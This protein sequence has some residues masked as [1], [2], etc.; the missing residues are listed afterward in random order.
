MP[1]TFFLSIVTFEILW[2]NHEVIKFNVDQFGFYKVNYED[3]VWNSIIDH[4]MHYHQVTHSQ[5][6]VR[7][8]HRNKIWVN[9]VRI[10][11]IWI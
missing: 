4:L 7:A 2:A 9:P 6:P 3:N 5:K 11:K 8:T 1:L 10:K